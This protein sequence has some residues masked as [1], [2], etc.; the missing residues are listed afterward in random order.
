MVS[1]LLSSGLRGR[2][3]AWGC[4][5]VPPSSGA[6]EK[7]YPGGNF[8]LYLKVRWALTREWG[9]E[10]PGREAN[11]PPRTFAE[12][13]GCGLVGG[14]GG[15]GTVPGHTSALDRVRICCSCSDG[16]VLFQL[17]AAGT[18][19]SGGLASFC[20][21]GVP[22]PLLF[23]RR[24]GHSKPHSLLGS[25]T[26][27]LFCLVKALVHLLQWKATWEPHVLVLSH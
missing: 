18:S 20:Q 19:C 27:S 14:G 2:S 17:W 1:L 5:A 11:R 10:H 6:S 12:A 8:K 3:T 21:Q 26:R 22:L 4:W 7:T 24:G 9:R 13:E 25:G 15:R 16:W 23:L